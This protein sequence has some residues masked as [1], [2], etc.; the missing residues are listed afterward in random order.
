[1]K[2]ERINRNTAK[3]FVETY[4]YSHS[5]SSFK[6]AYGLFEKKEFQIVAINDL[7]DTKTLAHFLKRDSV[8]GTYE[9]KVVAGENCI[10]VNGISIKVLLENG[11]LFVSQKGSHQKYRKGK[12]VLI[13]PHPKKEIPVGTFRS[14]IRQSGLTKDKFNM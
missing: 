4:H 8:H 12:F 7:M 6:T 11:F 5:L 13:V 14:I 1:M 3:E 10:I 9:H 2:A